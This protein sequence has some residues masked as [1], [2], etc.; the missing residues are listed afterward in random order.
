MAPSFFSWLGS[1]TS[2]RG[3]PE[4]RGGPSAW[5][6]GV[7]S[8]ACDFDEEDDMHAI[9]P[10]RNGKRADVGLAERNG[11]LVAGG[12][13]ECGVGNTSKSQCG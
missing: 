7:T 3:L 13:A 1:G 10:A 5:V 8:V 11:L 9:G 4:T 12:K 2:R 6:E